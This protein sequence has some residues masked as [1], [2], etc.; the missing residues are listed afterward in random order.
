MICAKYLRMELRN[1]LNSF[2]SGVVAGIVL[3]VFVFLV[4]WKVSSPGM[5][6]GRY[7][8]RALTANVITHFIS[9]SVFS[10]LLPFL[11]CNRLGM[12]KCSNGVLGITIIWAL[13][14]FAIKIF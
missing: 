2:L 14:T 10:N 6:L 4:V 8:D 11:L 3:P 12:I 1:R 9:I 13:L 7:I 5:E